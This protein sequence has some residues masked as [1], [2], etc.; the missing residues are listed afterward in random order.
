MK[1]RQWKTQ[2]INAQSTDET[3]DTTVR[4]LL[5]E[6]AVKFGGHWQ[7]YNIIY[8]TLY[9]QYLSITVIAESE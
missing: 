6:I 5:N 2:T 3:I 4:I 1:E 7:V 9:D 8:H